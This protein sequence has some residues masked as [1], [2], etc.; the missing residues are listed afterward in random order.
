MKVMGEAYKY[1]HCMGCCADGPMNDE[2]HAD[3]WL[4]RWNAAPRRTTPSGASDPRREKGEKRMSIRLRTV[5]GYRIAVCAARSVPLPGDVYLDD[6]DHHA[7]SV[8]FGADLHS[9][10]LA[11]LELGLTHPVDGPMLKLMESAESNN[12]NREWWDQCHGDTNAGMWIDSPHGVGETAKLAN[13][14]SS[15][16]QSDDS[17]SA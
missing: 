15:H 16:G 1:V 4:T 3:E 17:A 8:K 12:P 5:D 6:A 2:P 13:R 9:M 14:E 11:A 7:L 10:G